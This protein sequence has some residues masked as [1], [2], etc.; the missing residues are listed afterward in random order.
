VR[1][2]GVE[3]EGSAVFGSKV[4]RLPGAPAAGQRRVEGHA[5]TVQKQ[6]RDQRSGAVEAEGATGDHAQLVVEALDE[7]VGEF[8]FDIGEDSFFVLTHGSCGFDEGRELGARGPGEPSFELGSSFVDGGFFED[9]GERL[10]EQVG[11][12]ERRVMAL[13]RTQFVPLF[14]SEVPRVL[15]QDETRLLDRDR[16]IRV[17]ELPEMTR[18]LAA[19]F[20]DGFGREPEHVEEVEDDLCVRSLRLDGFDEG[21]GHVDGDCFDCGGA[22]F[23]ELFE[24]GV[25]R[26]G[27][28]SLGSPDDTLAVVI[29][30]GGDVVMPLAIAEL[31]D[32][33]A[34]ETVESLMVEPLCYDACDDVADSAPRNAHHP[35]HLGFVGDLREVGG[36]L[37]EGSGEAAALPRPRHELDANAAVRALHA[38]GR[39]FEENSYCPEVEMN[40]TYG[41]ALA[42]VAWT[43][44][45]ALRTTRFSPCRCHSENDKCSLKAHVVDEKT[46]NPDQCSGKFSDAHGFLW[47]FFCFCKH[48][49]AWRIVR[50]SILGRK[51]DKNPGGERHEWPSGWFSYP[52]AMQESQK[53]TESA[54]QLLKIHFTTVQKQH[55]D[56]R[57]AFVQLHCIV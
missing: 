17:V 45:A 53:D 51:S 9:S 14:R 49:N 42:I 37:L 30:D 32:A 40:P 39:V 43:D 6:H 7:A 16:C 5:P 44:P 8:C 24:E 47:P 25:E 57:S 21:A 29:D 36:H 20:F 27:A 31:V 41:L 35:R 10:F 55:G 22:L 52:L 23:A 4:R 1:P 12:V 11:A 2:S 33:D 28:F 48:Q 46:G 19:H 18:H 3:W 34:G 50:I 54:L 13:D 38:S 26:L 15:E 56:E